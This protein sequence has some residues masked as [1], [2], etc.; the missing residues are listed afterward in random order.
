M[1]VRSDVGLA[2]TQNAYTSLTVEQ[3]EKIQQVMEWVEDTIEND[4][5]FLFVWRDVKWYETSYQEII[6]LYAVLN[7]LNSDEF[8]LITACSEYP[9]DTSA[10]RGRW[11]DNPWNLC[12]YTSCTLEWD[13]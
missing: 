5:G 10:D 8:L 13:S 12:K 11:R 3:R 7:E 1:G 6:D 2:I 4:E 9:E